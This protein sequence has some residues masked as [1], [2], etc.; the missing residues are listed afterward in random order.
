MSVQF[1]PSRPANGAILC[2]LNDDELDVVNS[3]LRNNNV[4]WEIDPYGESKLSDANLNQI[5]SSLADPVSGSLE[6]KL[7]LLAQHDCVYGSGE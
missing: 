6:Q 5:M 7:K 3:A 1:Y 4:P 2:E